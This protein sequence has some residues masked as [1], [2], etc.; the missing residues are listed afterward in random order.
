MQL[1]IWQ[2]LI[3]KIV[4]ALRKNDYKVYIQ[5]PIVMLLLMTGPT[6]S[7]A[8]SVKDPGKYQF[9]MINYR[10][11]MGKKHF[12]DYWFVAGNKILII[13]HPSDKIVH[14]YL[15]NEYNLL[16]KRMSSIGLLNRVFDKTFGFHS[17][18]SL[19]PNNQYILWNGD[20]LGLYVANL[21]TGKYYHT[22]MNWRF[23]TPVWYP[24]SSDILI[25][26]K[27]PPYDSDAP[28]RFAYNYNP[29]THVSTRMPIYSKD[30]FNPMTTLASTILKPDKLYIL[31]FMNACKYFTFSITHADIRD[32]GS[33]APP[34]PKGSISDVA[35]IPH[36]H[37]IAWVWESET[38]SNDSS[39]KAYVGIQNRRY[40]GIHII[41]SQ[42]V[43]P[44]PNGCTP[45]NP[46]YDLKFN[47]FSNILSFMNDKNLIYTMLSQ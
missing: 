23:Q 39:W 22:N 38:K 15:L 11:I 6:G 7:K 47:L 13:S 12:W 32:D 46:I 43:P 10:R 14:D 36:S 31:I 2:Y 42:S 45:E 40:R 33:V 25:L 37:S 18:L 41:Y 26:S 19:S 17:K 9:H 29:F 30:I 1:S 4:N 20:D 16:T 3:I 35:L 24:N 34:Q 44:D 8:Q 27:V 21:K 28:F 5:I